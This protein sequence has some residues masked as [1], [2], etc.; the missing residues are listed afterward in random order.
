MLTYLF[1]PDDSTPPKPDA[2][3]YAPTSII[4]A[5]VSRIDGPLKTTGRAAYAADYNF[6]R[7]AYAVA[8]GST[9]ASGTI[10][11]IDTSAAEKMPGVLLVLNHENINATLRVPEGVRA[12]R[13]S[14]TRGPLQDNTIS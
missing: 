8:V 7:M 5:S 1:E 2:P 10:K 13:N 6:P 14:E 4:G 11:S 12:G 9:I 3:A